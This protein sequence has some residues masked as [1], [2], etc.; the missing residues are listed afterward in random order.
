MTACRRTRCRSGS[1][2]SSSAPSGSSSAAAGRLSSR[3]PSWPPDVVSGQGLH[4]GIGFLGVALAFGLTVVT[5]AYAVGHVSGAH[6]NPAVTIGVAVAR[7]FEWKDVPGYVVAQVV[8]GLL[9]GGALWGIARGQAGFVATGH[10]AAN[11]YGTHSP[12]GYSLTAVLFAEILLTAVFL[13]VI[14]GVTDSRAPNGWEPSASA[15]PHPHPPHLHPPSRTPRST[16]RARRAWRSSTATGR[17][18]SCGCSGW[19]PSSAGPSR[20][21]R[22]TSSPASTGATATSSASSPPRDVPDPGKGD[23]LAT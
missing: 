10:L 8:G 14:L 20:E 5:M 17:R 16:R 19:R 3:P 12:G 13:Y 6:F 4:L 2:P 18:G 21:R 9:A 11:G 22:S 1:A 15:R 23:P 7:R